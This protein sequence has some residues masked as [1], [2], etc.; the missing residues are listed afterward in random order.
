[1]RNLERL[2]LLDAENYWRQRKKVIASF[3]KNYFIRRIEPIKIL[4]AGCGIG[5]VIRLGS[6]PSQIIGIDYDKK[7][8]E[9]RQTSKGDLAMAIVGDLRTISFKREEFD[10][11]YCFDVLEHI[12]GAKEVIDSCFE[13][14]KPQGLLVLVFPDRET[15]FGFLTRITPFWFH[16]AFYKYIKGSQNAGKPGFGPCPTYYDKIVSQRGINEYCYSH[17]HKVLLEYGVCQKLF[18][19]EFLDLLLRRV[20]AKLLY[21]LSIGRLSDSH[22]GLVYVIQK[23]V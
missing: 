5:W 19:S 2:K 23:T 7:I 15:V 18:K 3:L 21:F 4:D 6:I 8:L 11:I 17:N 22:N 20:A 9:M 1:M 12:S 14:L 16:V 10:C 13:W